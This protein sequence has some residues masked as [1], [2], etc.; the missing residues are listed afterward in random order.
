MLRYS[1]QYRE[2]V[3]QL[4]AK[5]DGKNK[6]NTERGQQTDRYRIVHAEEIQQ[7]Q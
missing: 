2:C 4:Q 6:R 5:K 3:V 1:V 7:A